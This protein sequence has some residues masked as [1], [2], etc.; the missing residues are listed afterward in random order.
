MRKIFLSLHLF[1]LVGSFAEK[2]ISFLKRCWGSI[3]CKSILVLNAYM[4]FMLFKFAHSRAYHSQCICEQRH[5][6]FAGES[7]R[8]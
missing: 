8:H 5:A 7:E 2:S 3:F 6:H 4:D 1:P